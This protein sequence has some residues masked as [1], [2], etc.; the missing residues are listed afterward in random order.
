V[1]R[2]CWRTSF[3]GTCAS[4][5]CSDICGIKP[6]DHPRQGRGADSE[7]MGAPYGRVCVHVNLTLDKLTHSLGED[8]PL[9]IGAEVVSE[10]QPV[11]GSSYGRDG[12]FF[13]SI[14]PGFHFTISDSDGPLPGSDARSNLYNPRDGSSGP[15]V[16]TPALPVSRVVALDRSAKGYGLLPTSVAHRMEPKSSLWT[17]SRVR[18]GLEP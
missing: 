7:S 4:A 18:T 11:Y 13:M 5:R 6:P 15:S 3:S 17:Y 10:D 12:A 8:I 1:G 2:R 9:R 16:C 14:D